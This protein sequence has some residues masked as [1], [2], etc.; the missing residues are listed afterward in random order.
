M[1]AKR[2][3]PPLDWVELGAI[4]AA[5][6]LDACVCALVTG[7]CDVVVSVGA[8]AVCAEEVGVVA[9]VAACEL[10][11]PVDEVVLPDEAVVGVALDALEVDEVGVLVEVGEAGG[12]GA[13]A[14]GGSVDAFGPVTSAPFLAVIV[15]NAE[16]SGAWMSANAPSTFPSRPAARYPTAPGGGRTRPIAAPSRSIR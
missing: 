4:A 13:P 10:V 6:L 8:V 14:L 12:R 11:V 2:Y 9:V 3:P 7:V 16:E 1:S 15:T 5:P